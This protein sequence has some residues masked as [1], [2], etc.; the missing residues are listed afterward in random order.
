M[1]VFL[2]EHRVI[3][4]K[5]ATHLS[6][7][8]GKYE[9]RTNLQRFRELYACSKKPLYLI[10]RTLYPSRFFMDIDKC[11]LRV[12]TLLVAL[13][14][15]QDKFIVC[16]CEHQD[17]LH[18]IFKDTIVETPAAA[19]KL[20][21]Q[22]CS[23]VPFLAGFVDTSVYY[24]G[25]RM[26]GAHKTPTIARRYHVHGFNSFTNA[27]LEACS[28]HHGVRGKPHV[29][30]V[31]TKH[32]PTIS[33]YNTFDFSYIDVK[34][35]SIRIKSIM[36][37]CSKVYLISDSFYCTNIKKDHHSK[38]AYFIVDMKKKEITQRCLCKCPKKTEHA[39]SCASYS[40][41]KM[42]M[43]LIDF[44]KLVEYSSDIKENISTRL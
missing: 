8:G 24:S 14:Q 34:Y 17:G 36:K 1:E 33:K 3:D 20:C 19:I 29:K 25:L 16:S 23:R 18:L 31:V 39:L 21:G 38:N 32:V 44:Y 40:N 43:K 26:I 13:N 27:D 37:S 6:L 9:I 11:P 30:A 12:D 5:C 4:S 7:T 41:Q 2:K 10:E 35:G 42:K 15:I 22:I 28:I